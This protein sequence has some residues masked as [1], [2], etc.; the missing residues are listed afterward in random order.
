M[1]NFL[2]GLCSPIHCQLLLHGKPETVQQVIE[3]TI[4][5]E[6]TLNFDAGFEDTQDVNVVQHTASTQ[7]LLATHKLQESLD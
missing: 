6:Y 5:V 1:Q 4:N 3:D 7:D 2:T